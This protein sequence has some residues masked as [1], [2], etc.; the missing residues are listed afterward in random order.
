MSRIQN[1]QLVFDTL[2]AQVAAATT[3]SVFDSGKIIRYSNGAAAYAITLPAPVEG[4]N[5][6]FL[7]STAGTNTVT[8]TNPGVDRFFGILQAAGAQ[9][10]CSGKNNIAMGAAA[11]AAAVVGDYLYVISDGT[12]WF[13][14]GFGQNAGSIA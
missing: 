11:G 7:C 6:R 1:V 12:G 8:I 3:V 9:V 10:A 2:N 13:V 4:L 5:Y 14:E